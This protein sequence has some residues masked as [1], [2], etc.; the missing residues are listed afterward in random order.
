LGTVV[1]GL[2]AVVAEGFIVELTPATPPPPGPGAEVP[3][4][5]TVV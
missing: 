4:S 5:T 1:T 3:G 2:D